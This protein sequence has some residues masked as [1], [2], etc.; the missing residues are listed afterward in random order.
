MIR[1]VGLSATLPNYKDVAKFLGVSEATGLFYFDA[2]YRP[3][4]L[5]QTYIGVSESN[6]VKRLALMNEICYDK[7]RPPAT[8]V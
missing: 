6:L 5:T 3:V 7:V 1:I 2:A 8:L 4:P